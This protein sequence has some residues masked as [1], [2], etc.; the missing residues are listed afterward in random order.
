M[1]L[2]QNAGQESTDDERVATTL[3]QTS[4]AAQPPTQGAA[5]MPLS[6]LARLAGYDGPYDSPSH[7]GAPLQVARHAPVGA[8]GPASI[9]MMVTGAA[10]GW[11][12][13][14]RRR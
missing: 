1:P 13:M 7:A 4:L 3:E 6:A 12:F 11:A 10:A 8:T 14:R 5:F 2:T 9:L